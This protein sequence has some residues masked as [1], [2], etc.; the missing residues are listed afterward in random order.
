[1]TAASF[2]CPF[3]G[4]RCHVDSE[5]G[6]TMHTVPTCAEYDAAD[7]SMAF[8]RAVNDKLASMTGTEAELAKNRRDD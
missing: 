1:M 4:K 6:S 3:C 7:D 2:N 8:I 5:E